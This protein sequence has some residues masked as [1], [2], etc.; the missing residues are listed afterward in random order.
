MGSLCTSY[1][2]VAVLIALS[3]KQLRMHLDVWAPSFY[4][5][6]DPGGFVE[7]G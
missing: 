1:L 3:A 2:Y 7:S 4:L 6:V 5:V